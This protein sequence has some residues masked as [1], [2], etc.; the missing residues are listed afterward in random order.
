MSRPISASQQ[1]SLSSSF[2][3]S[4]LPYL[5]VVGFSFSAGGAAAQTTRS[6]TIL[7]AVTVQ[8]NHEEN[9]LPPAYAG[10]QMAKGG[11]LG[12]LGVRD[13]MSTPFSTVNY[14]SALIEDTQ[15][16]TLADV[17]TNDASVRTTTS[18]GGFGE[19]FQIRGFAVGT[20]D[21]GLNGLYGLL[22]ANRIPLEMVERVE[23]LK[24]PGTLMRGIPPNGS[25]GGSINIITKRADDTPLTR[26]TAT[27][28]NKANLE[29]HLDLG[30]RFGENNAWGIRFN[31][32]LRGGE[33]SIRDGSQQLGLGTLALD[34]RGTRLRW[35]LDAIYQDDEIDDF[36][37]Q[38]SFRP[39]ITEIPSAPDGRIAFY[40]G[41]TLTQHDRTIAS[42]LE[43]DLTENLTAHV[44][45]GYRDNTVKQVFPIFVNP[46]THARQG[47]DAEGNFGVMNS[48]YDSY[49]KTLSGDAGLQA[50]FNTGSIGHLVAL[51]ATRLSQETGNAY[52]PGTTAVP[53]NIYDPAPLPPNAP[54]RADTRRAAETT[55]DSIAITDTLSFAQE[56]VLLTLGARRQTVDVDSYST[57]TGEKTGNYNASA[58]SPVVGIVI[59]PRE[60]VALYGNFTEGLT[61]GTVVSPSYANAGEIL[62]PYKSKQYEA[63]VKVDW[64]RITT[65]AAVFQLARPAAQADDANVY[66]YFGEQRNR[67]LE[68]SAYGELRPG[69]RLMASAAFTQGK[70]TKTQGG[71]NEGNTAPGVPSRT[72]NL[73]L[74]WDTPWV[75]GLSLNGR[76]SHT[77]STYISSANTLRLPSVTTFDVGARYRTDVAGKEVVLRANIDNL[78]DKRYWLANGSFATN[79]AGRTFMLSASVDF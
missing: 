43:Y 34:Y 8:A 1:R 57:A 64:G 14:T 19:D 54:A 13:V 32:V 44:G 10:G 53:S 4:V 5:I 7:P 45:M 52:S 61:R 77:S 47:V 35:S 29:G 21:V 73:G 22:S 68:L 41:T 71:I 27:Y 56:R 24:G 30:R 55:L 72:F 69:L 2:K 63:G 6:A 40:P 48:Y 16:R 15:A 51:G 76:V 9:E 25:I 79:G 65:T 70:L 62:K 66:G 26:V 78:T 36:R 38:I 20:G 37:S 42:R 75:A 12:V 23:L 39:D 28:T 18:T 50:R 17:I 11:S 3:P 58:V 60:D 33:A 59:K 74:D 46:V 67:G 31:G 49:S